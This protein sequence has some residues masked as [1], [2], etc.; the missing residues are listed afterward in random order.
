MLTVTIENT[1]VTDVLTR[2]QRQVSDLSAAMEGIGQEMVSRISGRFE[3]ETDPS[4]TPWAPWAPSTVA[5]YPADGNRSVLDRYGDMLDSLSH[6]AGKTSVRIGFGTPYATYHEWG[7]KTMPR[8]GLLTDDPDAG[9][10]S[11]ADE[12][13]VLDVLNDYLGVP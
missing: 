13:A 3:T 12:A 2:I 1:A 11:P 10:L 4:G 8:R 7:T 9:T 5:S 6:E